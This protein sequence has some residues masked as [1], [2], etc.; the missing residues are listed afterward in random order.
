MALPG[1][2]GNRPTIPLTPLVGRRGFPFAEFDPEDAEKGQVADYAVESV[3]QIR[4]ESRR[5]P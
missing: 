3:A 5:N 4:R 1:P 2:P